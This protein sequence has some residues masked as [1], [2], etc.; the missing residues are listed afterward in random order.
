MIRIFVSPSHLCTLYMI[1]Y[2]RKTNMGQY[3]D[4]LV[5]DTPPK[6]KALIKVI[7]DTQKIYS[8]TRIINLSTEIPEEIDF[9][10]NV[11]KNAIRRIKNKPFIKPIYNFLLNL[12]VKKSEKNEARI[13]KN[14]L[15]GLGNVVELNVLTQISINSTL[16]KLYPNAQVNY[17]EHGQG[18][19]F[20]IQDI[21]PT[22]F[23]FY[24][25]FAD[26]FRGYLKNKNQ[27]NKYIKN[28]LDI[29]GFPGLANE[30]INSMDEK[31]EIKSFLCVQG[32]LVL[33]LMESMQLYYNV[34]DSFWTDYLELYIA[35]VINPEE[36]TFILKPH[37]TQSLKS[38]ELSKYYMLH[39]RKLKILV[40]EHGY[41][42][43][44]SVEV[45]YSLWQDNIHYVFSVFSSAL[46]YISKLYGN[47]T[48]KYYYAYDFFKKYIG[49]APPQFIDIYTGIEDVVKNVLTENCINISRSN[50]RL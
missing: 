25:V 41:S 10:P 9:T 22:T 16:F 36:Y 7:T 5:L 3:K 27:E 38:I 45:L 12:H 39:T 4:V 28:L 37:P 29:E 15:S 13:I 33:I 21:K 42:I 43:N 17:F 47:E 35:N 23:N 48:T 11:R 44:Y 18:D 31:E 46:Y 14:E 32:K 50:H 2:A 49:D 6:K 26:K 24:C 19:Y 20:F 34:P 40:L 8:W 30:V 1:L